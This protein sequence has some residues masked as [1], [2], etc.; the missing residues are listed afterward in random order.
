MK[1]RNGFVTNSSST[2]FIII[3]KE[4]ITVEYLFNKLGFKKGTPFE[5]MGWELCNNLYYR[6]DTETLNFEDISRD[7]G[8]ETANKWQ[9]LTKKGYFALRGNTSNDEDTL[10]SFFTTDSFEIDERNFYV[11][12]K[13]CIW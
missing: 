3:S 7:F 2:N 10:T 8:L 12:G 13:N 5:E 6:P 11:N 1:I 4:D 9:T